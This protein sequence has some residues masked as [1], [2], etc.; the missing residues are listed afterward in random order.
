MEDLVRIY[1]DG[2]ARGNPGPSAS[3]FMVFT[4]E[5][6]L[7]KNHAEYNG[8]KTN[9]FAEYRAVMLAFEWCLANLASPAHTSVELYS[10]SEIVVKQLN[11]VYKSKSKALLPLKVQV[12]GMEKGFESVR[13]I[14]VPRE[15]E[16][17]QEV[18]GSLNDLLDSLN[19]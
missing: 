11:G 16:H 17:I 7:L 3:G 2:A 12:Q 6:A 1:T 14:N 19:K 4:R 9:N 15:E 13:F 8:M 5:G 18:D 10:D